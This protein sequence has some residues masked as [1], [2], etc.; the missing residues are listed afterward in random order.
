MGFVIAKTLLWLLLPPASLII[1]VF[2]GVLIM[3]CCRGFG[4][5]LVALGIAALYG[6]SISPVSDALLKPLESAWPPLSGKRVKAEAIVV[7]GGGVRDLSWLGQPVTPTPEAEARLLQGVFLYRNMRVPL[8]LVGGN[9]DPSRSAPG[10]ADALEPVA[11]SLGVPA[12]DIVVEN[13]SRNTLEAA[14][15]VGVLI[16][17]RRIVLVTSAYHMKRSVA[18]FRKQGFEVIPAPAVYLSEQRKQS[19]YSFIPHAGALES[20]A[21]ACAEYLSLFW[22]SLAGDI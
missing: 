4:R 6:L 1:L 9:G 21:A 22:Y 11:R 2:S 5:F 12:R 14:R 18:L 8:V 20:S 16:K 13:R 10:D 3:G 7:L 15:N 17:V 19:A